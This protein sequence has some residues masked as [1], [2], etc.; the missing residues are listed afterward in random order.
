MTSRITWIWMA[1]LLVAIIVATMGVWWA[2]ADFLLD[3]LGPAPADGWRG[4]DAGGRGGAP[5]AARFE[6]NE[7]R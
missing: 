4:A 6:R 7:R 5:E 1:M 2:L 3:R